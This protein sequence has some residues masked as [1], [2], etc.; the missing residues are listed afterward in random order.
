M[1]LGCGL[2]MRRLSAISMILGMVL[3]VAACGSDG[4]GNQMA[5]VEMPGDN[6]EPMM[7][8]LGAWNTLM[9]GALHASDENGVLDAHYDDGVGHVVAAAPVQPAGTGTAI[10]NGRW[11]GIVADTDGWDSYE[12][13]KEQLQELGG[14]AR[15]TA[16]F[17][18]GG[19][20]AELGLMGIGFD[21][22]G[23]S[24]LTTDRV[25]VTD[26]RFQPAKSHT[27]TYTSQQGGVEV[28]VTG[29]FT[30]GGV[31]G[32]TDAK[33]VV[34]HLSG[35]LS[36]EY[37]FGPRGLGNFQSVFYGTKDEN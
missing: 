14:E 34:G 32:G 10:W 3:L 1:K 2:A 28:T 22:L 7:T 30:G 35:P 26:G 12:V 27:Y 9:P 25:S 31:F 5:P 33:G 4:G 11:S 13:T 29:D 19:V 36:L 37:G 18:N 17:D 21:F 23:L 15:I 24:E 20:E 6:G 16:Y 8:E